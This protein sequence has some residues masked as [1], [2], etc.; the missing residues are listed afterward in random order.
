[1]QRIWR[2]SKHVAKRTGDRDMDESVLTGAD[3]MWVRALFSLS[4]GRWK[5]SHQR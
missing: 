1:M 5:G 3:D 2:P 4:N